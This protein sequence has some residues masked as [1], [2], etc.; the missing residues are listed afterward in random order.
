MRE[1]VKNI[2]GKEVR[3]GHEVRL[4]PATDLFMRGV[5]YAT[6]KTIGRKWIH[7]YHHGSKTTHKVSFAFASQYFM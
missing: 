6:V 5:R 2:D 1:T 4:H 7:L 3:E